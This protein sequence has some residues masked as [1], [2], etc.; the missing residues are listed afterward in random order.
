MNNTLK[1]ISIILLSLVVVTLSFF[2]YMLIKNDFKF[3]ENFLK[4][5]NNQSNTLIDN[6]EYDSVNNI[7]IK[8]N[9]ADIYINHATDNKFKVELYSD[10]EKKHSISLTDGNLNIELEEKQFSFFTKHARIILYV[11]SDFSNKFDIVNTTGDIK[12]DSYENASFKVDVTTGDVKIDKADVLDIVTT[13]GDITNNYVNTISASCSTGDIK[14]DTVNKSLVL[15]T[16]TG[17]VKINYIN[18]NSL[19][20]L[21]L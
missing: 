16:T 11:P 17:D 7:S 3:D 12:A 5:F 10:N 20:G 1:I 18:H 8:S 21:Y 9:T 4:I 19:I 2:L 13:T 14:L 6:K 15:K